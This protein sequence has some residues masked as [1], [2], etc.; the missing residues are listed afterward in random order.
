MDSYSDL[1]KKIG[2][3]FAFAS[4]AFA[5]LQRYPGLS[6]LSAALLSIVLLIIVSILWFIF[7]RSSSAPA[8]AIGIGA[9]LVLISLSAY[10]SISDMATTAEIISPVSGGFSVAE[11]QE[12]GEFTIVVKGQSSNISAKRGSLGIFVLSKSYRTRFWQ[13]TQEQAKV[14]KDGKWEAGVL[15][16]PGGSFV[17]PNDRF[18]ISA[19]V[20]PKRLFNLKAFSELESLDALP[21]GVL[22]TETI[23][24]NIKKIVSPLEVQQIMFHRKTKSPFDFDVIIRNDRDSSALITEA[25]FTFNEDRLKSGGATKAIKGRFE[26]RFDESKAK[27]IRAHAAA[28][29]RN[30]SEFVQEGKKFVLIKKVAERIPPNDEARIRISLDWNATNLE[31]S[32]FDTLTL[33]FRFDRGAVTNGK[34]EDL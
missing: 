11:A 8:K 29:G 15:L 2:P 27:I 25:I 26:L 6:M 30:N 7:V 3:V 34:M 33:R 16:N 5:F 20:A 32:D 22:K 18:R 12:D 17:K 9:I 23:M 19:I 13:L 28:S 21:E 31:R 10:L 4:G 24:T 14:A 1:L